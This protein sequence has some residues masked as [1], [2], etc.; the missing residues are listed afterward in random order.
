MKRVWVLVLGLLIASPLI[1][2][3]SNADADA[4]WAEIVKNSKPAAPPAEWNTKAPTPEDM[5]AFKRKA[6]DAA[7]QLARR[8]KKLYET[9]PSHAKASEARQKEK[10]FRQQATALR[11]VKEDKP[12]ERASAKAPENHGMDPGFKEKYL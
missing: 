3:E 2:A 7:E 4:A 9:Y 1:A 8:T 11:A 6:G 5:A 12:T 10:T